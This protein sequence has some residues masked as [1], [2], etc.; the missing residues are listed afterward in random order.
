MATTKNDIIYLVAFIV[1]IILCFIR[2]RCLPC[3]RRRNQTDQETNMSPDDRKE[4]IKCRLIVKKAENNTDFS[5]HKKLKA[6]NPP[7]QS[8]LESDNSKNGSDETLLPEPDT[9]EAIEHTTSNYN[10]SSNSAIMNLASSIRS[11]LTT[12][13]MPWERRPSSSQHVVDSKKQCPICLDDYDIG[14]EICSSPN[15]ECPHVF[16]VACMSE[17]LMKRNECPLCRA[18]YLKVS[19]D[20]EEGRSERVETANGTSINIASANAT[21]AV[22]SSSSPLGIQTLQAV[23]VEL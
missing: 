7:P 19:N 18:D 10:T 3:C 1:Y 16:H 9:D 21:A 4:L 17:W 23:A 13:Q 6:T 8:D 11:S 12:A 14:D 22:S 20:E 2:C 15:H 5:I